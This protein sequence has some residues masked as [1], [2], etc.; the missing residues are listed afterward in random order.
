MA[1][2][3]EAVVRTIRRSVNLF[4]VRPQYI[5]TKA[6]RDIASPVLVVWGAQDQIFP[7]AHAERAGEAAANVRVEIFDECGHWP[8]MEKAP[9]FNSLV[10]DFLSA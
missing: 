2:A 3:K 6:L 1:G 7:A 8:H 4:G 10:L 5:F 9:A